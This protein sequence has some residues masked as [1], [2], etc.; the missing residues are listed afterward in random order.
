MSYIGYSKE[1][2]SFVKLIVYEFGDEYE[3]DSY[4]VYFEN[5]K[6]FIYGDVSSEELLNFFDNSKFC[7]FEMDYLI[8]NIDQIIAN[9]ISYKRRLNEFITQNI[10]AVGEDNRSVSIKGLSLLFDDFVDIYN[11]NIFDCESFYIS[12]FGM[13]LNISRED[14]MEFTKGVVKYNS[15]NFEDFY[16]LIDFLKNLV[17]FNYLERYTRDFIIYSEEYLDIVDDS[18]DN[19]SIAIFLTFRLNKIL[20]ELIQNP[21]NEIWS[22]DKKLIM[23]TLKLFSRYCREY[24]LIFIDQTDENNE[25]FCENRDI[26]YLLLKYLTEFPINIEDC[27][28]ILNVYSMLIFDY[29]DYKSIHKVTQ[30]VK[31]LVL[32]LMYNYEEEV[33]TLFNDIQEVLNGLTFYYLIG[34]NYVDLFYNKNDLHGSIREIFL[35]ILKLIL[36][37]NVDLKKQRFIEFINKFYN[38]LSDMITYG[39]DGL[40][41]YIIWII[42]DIVK[43]SDNIGELYMSVNLLINNDKFQ[44]NQLYNLIYNLVFKISDDFKYSFEG[45]SFCK[46]IL[47]KDKDDEIY[48]HRED[49]EYFYAKSILVSEVDY[50]VQEE[51]ENFIEAI[52]NYFNNKT[53]LNREIYY[54]MLINNN[55]FDV[56]KFDI[57]YKIEECKFNISDLKD[58]CDFLI[59]DSPD[60]VGVEFGLL[61]SSTLD[62]NFYEDI[63]KKLVFKLTCGDIF[64][65]INEKFMNFNEKELF[66]K[67]D[68]CVFKIRW[69]IGECLNDELEEKIVNFLNDSYAKLKIYDFIYVIILNKYLSNINIFNDVNSNTFKIKMIMILIKNDVEDKMINDHYIYEVFDCCFKKY[70]VSFMSLTQFEILND[71]YTLIEKKYNELDNNIKYKEIEFNHNKNSITEKKT[72][73]NQYCEILKVI[74]KALKSAEACSYYENI[75]LSQNVDFIINMLENEDVFYNDVMELFYKVINNKFD[76]KTFIEIYDN[77]LKN[78]FIARVFVKLISYYPKI[79]LEIFKNQ[80]FL[81]L[82]IKIVMCSI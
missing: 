1:I 16:F 10:N 33:I 56:Y 39:D 26:I 36:S 79:I 69:L 61:L 48:Y 5:V 19:I 63:L 45:R 70:I 30:I 68:S 7:I 43:N 28:I 13:F 73:K 29:K 22:K 24:N 38:E 11:E 49:R 55:Y 47:G 52:L 65:R 23:V 2:P 25:K 6:S 42:N 32:P 75:F 62:I 27:K 9:N 66:E 50:N 20:T 72:F 58:E 46:F 82:Y 71:L 31:Y 21:E 37:E 41:N 77:G 60:C 3:G 53:A 44:G 35:Y 67:H 64:R 4:L 18:L 54:K 78:K 14:F 76:L 57:L 74:N 51:K 15:L 8:K 12:I 80:E 17:D 40:F 81:D 59:Y 34:E